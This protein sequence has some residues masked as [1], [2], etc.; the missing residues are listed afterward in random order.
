MGFDQKVLPPVFA[1]EGVSAGLVYRRGEL[2]LSADTYV[3]RGYRLR[4]ADGILNLQNDF[5]T[6]D[7][8]KAGA[9]AR[10]GAARGP[11]TAYYSFYFNPLGFG[12]RL[13]MQAGDLGLWRV[14]GVPV[15]DRLVLGV[16]ALRADVTGGGPG[17][18]YYHFGSYWQARLLRHPLPLPAVPARSAHLQQ[19]AGGDP[20]RDPPRR[21]TTP[22]RTPWAW[23]SAGGG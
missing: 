12:R 3:V 13:I 19:P 2:S 5:S 1:Q 10:L 9:G 4:Q 23:S 6:T 7:D 8:L 15:L 20:R 22:P 14:H 16:G 21:P 17:L 11:L 18:D